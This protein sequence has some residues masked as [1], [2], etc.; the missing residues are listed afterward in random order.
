MTHTA[1]DLAVDVV[2]NRASGYRFDG[3]TVINAPHGDSAYPGSAGALRSTVD[4]MYRFDRALKSGKLFSNAI[5]TKAWT[6][7]GHLSR[8][9]HFQLKRSTVMAG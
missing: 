5:T 4:D 8:R 7:Y 3:E 6:P 1:Y 9:R 2:P